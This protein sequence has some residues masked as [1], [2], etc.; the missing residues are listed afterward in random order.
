MSAFQ[1]AH[2]FQLGTNLKAWLFRIARNAHIDGLRRRREPD[3]FPIQE[4]AL[5]GKTAS[6]MHRPHTAEA[7]KDL[8]DRSG[9]NHLD[10][11]GDEV[12][13]LLKE[14]PTNFRLALVL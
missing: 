8:N 5:E 11:F 3:L 10:A 9:I 6:P 12:T 7:W 4:V 14:L 2:P 13:R 1:K